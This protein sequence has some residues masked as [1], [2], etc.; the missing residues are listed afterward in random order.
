MATSHVG[1]NVGGKIFRT[2]RTTLT[3]DPDCFF[4]LMLSGRI[5]SA[6]DDD[7]NYLIDRDGDIFRHVLNYLRGG[8]L[9]LPTG[10]NELHQLLGEADFFQLKALKGHV[11]GLIEVESPHPGIVGLNVGGRL[12]QTT[13]ETLAGLPNSMLSDIGKGKVAPLRDKSGNYWIDRDGEIFRHILNFLRNGRL[14]LPDTFRELRMLAS[15]ADFY[16]MSLLREHVESLVAILQHDERS[17]TVLDL[18]YSSGEDTYT[19][20][21]NAVNLNCFFPFLQNPGHSRR[22][23]PVR[24]D[25]VDTMFGVI[26]P[27]SF[28]MQSTVDHSDES[29]DGSRW[30]Y[31]NV[32]PVPM[33]PYPRGPGDIR[34]HVCNTCHMEVIVER[35]M[36]SIGCTKLRFIKDPMRRKTGDE[37]GSS[38]P[39]PGIPQIPVPWPA[40]APDE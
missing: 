39:G 10:F 12:Y 19:V 13:G 22:V 25:G 16:G 38:L 34:R 14:V 11:E 5:P 17:T 7:G 28:S 23:K 26:Q 33:Y 3:R 35:N 40:F 30:I 31:L 2:S 32:P 21:T 15:E 24:H 8:Q 20:Y 6:R 4:S 1:L 29:I 27:F 18:Y 36:E 9:L 37:I